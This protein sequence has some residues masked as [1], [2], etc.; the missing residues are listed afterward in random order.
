[1]LEAITIKNF[2][3]IK[4]PIRFELRPITLFFGENSSGKSTVLQ[5][6]HYAYE[7]FVNRNFDPDKS[8]IGGKLLDLGGFKNFVHKKDIH[9]PIEFKFD[10]NIHAMDAEFLENLQ[11][12][13]WGE[14]TSLEDFVSMPE[15][16]SISVWIKWSEKL[17]KPLLTKYAVYIDGEILA[18]TESSSDGKLVALTQYNCN[19][20]I[21]YK[22]KNT[23]ESAP[24]FWFRD[25]FE[26]EKDILKTLLNPHPEYIWL[27]LSQDEKID[28]AKILILEERK[29]SSSQESLHDP[30]D[31]WLSEDEE[32]VLESNLKTSEIDK[33]IEEMDRVNTNVMVN[34]EV[35]PL[36]KVT[37]ED[38]IKAMHRCSTLFT[39]QVIKR[40]IKLPGIFGRYDEVERVALPDWSKPFLFATDGES[41]GL[42]KTL[43]LLFIW[44]GKKL[45]ELLYNLLYLGPIREIPE[46]NFKPKLTPELSRYAS[47]L[48][49]W[50]ILY[51]S[52]NL[53]FNELNKWIGEKKLNLNYAIHLRRFRELADEDIDD[54]NSTVLSLK[55]WLDDVYK[56][57]E[58]D[59]TIDDDAYLGDRVKD[60]KQFFDNGWEDFDAKMKKSREKNGILLCPIKETKAFLDRDFSIN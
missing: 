58:A 27:R 4:E 2:K 1:M 56:E 54:I 23:G 6:L 11:R 26:N 3:G 53:F 21:F 55:S 35:N 12:S 38:K 15:T 22:M 41:L 46:R 5:A 20:Q 36:N 17:E 33:K 45:S 19:H 42:E 39:D 40:S 18:Q 50:D 57:V 13:K 34:P 32:A 31:N 59:S 9:H 51:K 14:P 44:P 47:G 24:G 52:D 10:L 60:H 48:G 7:I 28:L 29:R 49:C 43:D 25:R 16:A 37:G 8:Q 30:K